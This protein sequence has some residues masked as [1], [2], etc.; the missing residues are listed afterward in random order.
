MSLLLAGYLLYGLGAVAYYTFMVAW[1][2]TQGGG[3]FLT[4]AFWSC[5]AVSAIIAPWIWRGFVMRRAGGQS[6]ATLVGVT[7]LASA[8]PLVTDNAFINCISAIAYGSAS[9]TVVAATTAFI[10][11]NFPE[12]A[13]PT[14]VGAMTTT[15]SIGLVI[16]PVAAGFITDLVGT[17]AAGLWAGAGWLIVSALLMLA[18]KDLALPSK[19]AVPDARVSLTN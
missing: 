2:N 17:L 14:A 10:R 11:R 3:T 1:F 8:V 16:G 7:V 12:S 9:F 13:W 6:G 15:F 5:L 4:V 18:Q 19:D